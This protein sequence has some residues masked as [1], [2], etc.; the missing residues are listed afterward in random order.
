MITR[1]Q[2]DA[3]LLW[4]GDYLCYTG[5]DKALQLIINSGKFPVRRP[6]EISTRL[7]IS[8]LKSFLAQKEELLTGKTTKPA[9]DDLSTDEEDDEEEEEDVSW[10]I[11]VTLI[12]TVS[13]NFPEYAKE[14]FDCLNCIYNLG[15]YEAVIKSPL[16]IALGEFKSDLSIL[17]MCCGK[18]VIDGN[19]FFDVVRKET[20][21]Y[22]NL[23]GKLNRMF[24]KMDIKEM[25]GK[26]TAYLD[27]IS[28]LLKAPMLCAIKNDV[29][30]GNYT[31]SSNFDFTGETEEESDKIELDKMI[32][33]TSNGSNNNDDSKSD[34]NNVDDIKDLDDIFKD[35]IE[36]DSLINDIREGKVPRFTLTELKGLVLS[37]EKW[38]SIM[39][40]P[41][42]DPVKKPS[43][44][45]LSGDE[46]EN[47][48]ATDC[49]NGNVATIDVDDG[50]NNGKS[51]S[52]SIIDVNSNGGSKS[53][54]I[55]DVSKPSKARINVDRKAEKDGGIYIRPKRV[56]RFFSD[57]EVNNL[58][59]GVRQYGVGKWSI[60]LKHYKFND[61]TSVD[62]KDKWRNMTTKEDRHKGVK[63]AISRVQNVKGLLKR[64][65][66]QS[67]SEPL[68]RFEGLPLKKQ[69][70][71]V[72]SN[73]NVNFN[74]NSNVNDNSN[75]NVSVG[76]NNNNKN[77][78]KLSINK[79]G[80]K[81]NDSEND[82]E[83]EDENSDIEHVADDQPL[84]D[85]EYIDFSS[86]NFAINRSSD[87]N[88]G[89]NDNDTEDG[90]DDEEEYDD[91]G[92]DY[93]PLTQQF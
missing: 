9:S 22:S 81:I 51:R 21:S 16:G 24:K 90:T 85:D 17:S 14:K 25:F 92:N 91:G 44:E 4:V 60:I 35:D 61:R 63:N 50:V 6:S 29:M 75:V 89:G 27:K 72:V 65:E 7:N 3:I 41:I 36:E 58:R 76:I 83:G 55:L 52:Q 57:E 82:K 20:R 73:H 84:T 70:V 32:E 93:Q 2:G 33:I 37:E 66:S 15:T 80:Y 47:V 46:D 42:K 13:R 11:I 86:G 10:N 62:L 31:P 69:R 67:D 18:D 77:D 28:G 53:Q 26:L 59:E 87:V 48:N 23:R 74:V 88:D 5:Q 78:P 39:S 30:N 49:V 43:I 40:I 1:G 71:S 38:Y 64:T 34:N 19:P 8:T 12:T 68:Q 45:S 56:N 54:S 79:T